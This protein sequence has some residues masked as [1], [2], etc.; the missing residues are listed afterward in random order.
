MKCFLHRRNHPDT[1]LA[2]GEEIARLNVFA[3]G[4]V[5]PFRII[6]SEGDMIHAEGDDFRD[7]F[8]GRLSYHDGRFLLIYNTRYNAWARN[9]THHPKIRFTV[10]HDLG[11]YYLDAHREFLVKRKKAIESFTEF[12]S[13]KQVERDDLPARWNDDE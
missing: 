7:S 10:A 9:S 13:N 6:V 1:A 3:T 4:P 5:D 2:K 11:H 8:D 12:E